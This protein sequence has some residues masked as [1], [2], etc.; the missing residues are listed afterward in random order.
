[1][2]AVN[3]VKGLEFEFNLNR[4]LAVNI[5]EVLCLLFLADGVNEQQ[6]LNE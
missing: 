1:M 3:Q 4:N 2:A 6:L 5:N